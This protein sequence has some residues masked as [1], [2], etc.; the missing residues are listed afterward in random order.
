M[1]SLL[2]LESTDGPAR[3]AAV[4][5]NTTPRAEVLAVTV[6]PAPPG[7]VVLAVRGEVDMVTSPLLR[8]RLQE[9]L[10]PTCLDLVVDLTE[11]SFF[12]AA[13]LTDLVIARRTAQEVGVRL[14]LV[15]RTRVVLRPLTITGLD[16][17]FDVYPDI[18][19]ARTRLHSEP[20][21]SS[22]A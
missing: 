4:Q 16:E 15:A 5:P 14:R 18:A 12:G 7:A 17:L 11:V 13:G 20:G 22:P 10:R 9:H 3:A 1:A 6:C 19:H 8:D 2:Q 21:V